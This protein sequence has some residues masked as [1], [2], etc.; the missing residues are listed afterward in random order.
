M[1]LSFH[2]ADIS[3]ILKEKSAFRKWINSEILRRSFKTGKINLILCS[4]D[5]LLELNKKYL[6]HNFYT[7]IITFNYNEAN[8]ISGDLFISIDRIKENTLIFNTIFQQ[9]LKRVIIHGILHLMGHDDNSPDLKKKIHEEED[10][11]LKRFPLS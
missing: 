4:D 8:L 3:F 1:P 2:S 7:D 9:E 6:N 11:A 5:Y 10:E